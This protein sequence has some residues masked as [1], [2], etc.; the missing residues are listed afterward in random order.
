MTTW[1]IVLLA[2]AYIGAMFALAN[3]AERHGAFRPKSQMMVYSLALTV[4]CTSWTY[5][6]AVG[7][8]VNSGLDYVPIY[9]GPILMYLLGFP[10]LR[11]LLLVSRQH[12]ATSLTDFISAR[13]GK[14]HG[15]AAVTALV[16][17]IV[18]VPYVAL[19][20]KAVANSYQVLV[21]SH[22]QLLL[23]YQDPALWSALA[24][25]L[26]AMLF[27]SRK[28]ALTERNRG[29]LTTV[30]FESVVKLVALV[31]LALTVVL[32]LQPQD[33]NYFEQFFAHQPHV[34][35]EGLTLG[36]FT[37]TLLAAVAIFLLPRQ[38][39]VTFVE[40]QHP[41]QLYQA[42]FF[43]VMYLIAVTLV[44]P[45][46]AMAGLQ[47]FPNSTQHADS[48][49]LQ[50]PSAMQWDFLT[51]LVFVGGFSAA[52]SMIIIATLALGIMIS[53]DVVMPAIL[54]RRQHQG[55][56]HDYSQLILRVRR[57]MILLVMVLSYGFYSVFARHYE[58]AET[59]LLAFALVIQLAPAVIGGL[60]WR[61]GH[62]F[63]VYAGLTLGVGLW[64]FCLM[65]PQLI[66]AQVL[67]STVIERGVLG[68][69]WLK[70]T[71]LFGV[72][73]D[74][75][76]H[77]VLFSLGAN[78]L[79]Y[80]MVSMLAHAK[81]QDR[82]QAGAF[83]RPLQP[84][85]DEQKTLGR[86][87]ASNADLMTLLERFVGTQRA[88]ESLAEYS[89]RFERPAPSLSPPLT[90]VRHV[91]RELAGVI[92]SSSASGIIK[93]V[94][95]GREL[96]FEDV[97]TLFDDT[98]QAIQFSRKILFSTLENLSQG[99]SVVDRDL[100]LVAWNKQYLTMFD[101]PE[102]LIRVGRPIADI[103]RFNAERGLCGPGSADEH[104][105]KRL[106]HMKNG[107]T[108][109]F[110]RLRPDGRVIEI[111]GN[112]IPGGG[113]VTSFTDIT[114]HVQALQELAAAKTL[115]EQRVQERTAQISQ[116]NDE[117]R[118]ENQLRAETE[119]QLLH[120]KAEA[121]AANASKTRF[122]ALTSH[123]IL[124]PLNAARLFAASLHGQVQAPAER[125]LVQLENSLKA[126]ED[127]MATLLDIARLDE[128]K[129]DIQ[130]GAVD[131]ATM[132]SQLADE[133][134]LLA[135]Q[136]GLQL[137]VRP[138]GY[139][140][141]SHAT[142]LR[143]IV[144]NLLSNAI[145]YT[146]S[147]KVLLGCRRQGSA[148]WLEIWDTGP[149]MPEH[150]LSM[151]FQDFYRV[152]QTARGQSG[153]G[154]G[155]GVVQRMAKALGHRLDVRSVVGK[156]SCFRIQLHPCAAPG[157][158]PQDTEH[159]MLIQRPVSGVHILC[160]DDEAANLAALTTLLEQWQE[161][162]VSAYTDPLLIAADLPEPDIVIIDYQL[163][164]PMNGL[165]WCLQLRQRWPHIAAILVSAAPD[166]TLPSQAKQQDIVFLAKPIKPAAL[167]ATLKSLK[168]R[169]L[170]N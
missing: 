83:V 128:G 117:L 86:N 156:G 137:R 75:L 44:V 147:G 38:F 8:A 111:S 29:V 6:G 69:A 63:G 103:V 33:V 23:W 5:Y 148:I 57:A 98:R 22:H 153:V 14:R 84:L 65:V 46:I 97:V 169:A 73:L 155:L 91:E 126:T 110:Q 68:L 20:L 161:G 157:T 124:Q 81:L 145:K 36:F 67:Q 2:F 31:A 64:F 122:L 60:Y 55:F 62:A 87:N 53:N 130:H 119:Q 102:G 94:L 39:H 90:F 27:G 132:V 47:I 10:V 12:N 45:P 134:G 19:Q 32:V 66:H 105:A 11:K 58:L 41:Q 26:F 1:W 89:Q 80:L 116:I 109:V 127:L 50:I 115:L 150:E 159:S 129:L 25:A 167:R 51:G 164:Q 166:P 125:A 154:L 4:Y 76:S 34:S 35:A 104:V 52:T 135:Q 146:A 9:L 143:R 93:A 49:V 160:I 162:T 37:K 118:A 163:N 136:K 95:D 170:S 101:Y 21:P 158:S 17:L 96:A 77:G 131:L 61:R 138:G 133:M 168:L 59:G 120:A 54:R 70:P 15:I 108:H 107:T 165:Q 99:V 106:A 100:Q 48:F 152:Q 113:F 40:N 123:D 56:G 85:P 3:W 28:L 144:Q 151:I 141:T 142:Y 16:C 92:G 42:R 30:A 79:G 7:S 140:V 121:E 82:L 78:V 13:Y 71:A 139:W 112:P 149:G 24:M 18:V 72:Q 43:L 74:T 114:E 88:S